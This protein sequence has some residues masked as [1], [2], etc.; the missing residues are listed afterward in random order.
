MQKNENFDSVFPIT[1][2]GG[3]SFGDP[4]TMWAPVYDRRSCFRIPI[5]MVYDTYDYI[6]NGV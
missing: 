4:K 2:L 6:V 1:N 3:D 5:T